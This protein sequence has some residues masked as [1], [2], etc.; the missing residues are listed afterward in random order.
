MNILSIAA[1]NTAAS[2]AVLTQGALT[3]KENT[4]TYVLSACVIA[5][6]PACSCAFAL[7]CSRA[8]VRSCLRARALS[9]CRASMPAC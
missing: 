5:C 1:P 9:C 7:S 2:A 8:F 6:V 3:R 4:R